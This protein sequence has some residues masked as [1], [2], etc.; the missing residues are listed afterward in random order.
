MMES[1]KGGKTSWNKG[2]NLGL[3]PRLQCYQEI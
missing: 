2:R 3:K 1:G